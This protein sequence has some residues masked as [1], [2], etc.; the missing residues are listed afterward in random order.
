MLSI[1]TNYS[2][3]NATNH[4][5]HAHLN[6]N[7]SIEKL[8]TGK[9]INAAKDDPAGLAIS[10]RLSA[11]VQGL[12]KASETIEIHL[13]YAK[14]LMNTYD[15]MNS[16][17]IRMRELTLQGSNGILDQG[18][19][20]NI[21]EE[22]GQLAEQMNTLTE[23]KINALTPL[24]D[25]NVI[26]LQIGAN[27]GN[28]FTSTPYGEPLKDIFSDSPIFITDAKNLFKTYGSGF[29]QNIEEAS[30]LVQNGNQYMGEVYNTLN[31]TLNNIT[32]QSINLEI[33]KG[34]IEDTDFALET[35]KLA[36]HQIAEQAGIAIAAQANASV[37][38][39]LQLI[40]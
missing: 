13:N 15:E 39:V 17:L 35:T 27:V 31:H 36:K 34:N 25:T 7:S 22:L 38:I 1:H 37:S 19:K 9:R 12:K 20:D 24:N 33:S 5:K 3:A 2:S 28:V 10:M 29:L 8:S 40:N 21:A 6:R 23:V 32:S 4:V 11:Q 16:I 26:Q 30:T 18:S 14:V